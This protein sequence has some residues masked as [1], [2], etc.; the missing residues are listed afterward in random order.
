MNRKE[1][2]RAGHH[3]RSPGGAKAGLPAAAVP[4]GQAALLALAERRH[5]GGQFADAAE[6]CRQILASEPR[7]AE[8]HLI[9]GSAALNLGDA[10]AARIHLEQ[11]IAFRPGDPRAWIVLSS[12]FTRAGQLQAALEA[13]RRAIEIAPGNAVAHVESGNVLAS[14]RQF[15]PACEAYQRA[16][17]LQPGYADAWVNLGSALFCQGLY[18]DAA[19]AQRRALALHSGH[20]QALRNLAAALRQLGDFDAALSTYRRAT[21]LAP[22][23]A[24]AHRDEALLLLLLGQYDEGWTK[25]EWRWK[26]ATMGAQPIHGAR[27]SGEDPGGRRILLQ[28]EQGIGDTLQFLRYAPLVAGRGGRVVLHLP[29]S[30]SHLR[31]EAMA[32]ATEIASTAEPLPPF[33]LYIPLMS[34]PRVFGTDADAAPRSVPYLQAPPDTAERWRQ[35]LDGHDKPRVGLV[36]AGNP[37]H[38]NDLNRS[39]GLARLLPLIA[40][41]HAHFFSLQVGRPPAELQAVTDGVI[42]DLSAGL[43]DFGETAGAIEALD[44][45]ISV[46]TAVAHLAGALGKPVWLLL[47][48]VP[49]WRWLLGRDD[50]PWYPTMR[51]FRQP[52]RGDWDEVIARMRQELSGYVKIPGAA[53]R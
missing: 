31:G 13:C 3:R 28:A 14:L 33:D 39:I 20:V 29:P 52:R 15:D 38:E 48:H 21:A 18:E 44:L 19:A 36:W 10:T 47:P 50:S 40:D 49:D 1:R 5:N 30:L 4:S 24:E 27:W 46:D 35:R 9:R 42:H 8:A 41:R 26:A 51:L 16:L 45:V 25:Y 32:A 53:P 37:I 6:I 7:N 43:V 34:L 2:R 23:F 12:C 17:S 22:Q 11:S